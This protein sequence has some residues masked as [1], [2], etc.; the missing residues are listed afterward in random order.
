MNE[1]E[2]ADA[3]AAW[4][5]HPGELPPEGLDPEVLGTIYALRPDL[6]P[7]PTLTADD[8]LAS[9]TEGP[10]ADTGAAAPP[11]VVV[12]EPANRPWWTLMLGGGALTTLAAAA[13]LLI[14][15]LPAVE[16]AAK[17]PPVGAF[18]RSSREEAPMADAPQGAAAPMEEPADGDLAAYG[19]N[20]IP[21]LEQAPKDT[22]TAAQ[23]ATET[24]PPTPDAA[25]MAREERKMEWGATSAGSAIPEMQTR[26]TAS[27]PADEL[28]LSSSNASAPEPPAMDDAIGA[29]AEVF[30]AEEDLDEESYRTVAQETSAAPVS[31]VDRTRPKRARASA[32]QA[33]APAAPAPTSAPASG[34]AGPTDARQALLVASDM[35]AGGDRIGAANLLDRWITAP[36]ATG[37]RVAAQAAR[38][39]LD[40]GDA[41]RAVEVARRGLDLSLA[42]TTERTQLLAIYTEAL[43]AAGLPPPSELLL[44]A[45]E[46]AK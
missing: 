13:A 12:P 19:D 9:L 18:S 17:G 38:Y 31:T 4:L 25:P 28:G 6:A 40:A 15:A 35:A 23:V 8:I 14:L 11:P 22:P 46:P 39:L 16:N 34:A 1:Q 33:E 27:L 2:H 32:G 7:A 41:R 10:L 42:Q 26:N 43:A 3:L 36:P 37:Q 30:D 20:A 24:P 29:G 45:A 5:D 44:D 21:E